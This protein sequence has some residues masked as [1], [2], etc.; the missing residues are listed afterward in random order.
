MLLGFLDEIFPS[1]VCT[2]VTSTLQ[3]VNWKGKLP[4]LNSARLHIG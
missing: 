4:L 2:Y 1:R 3:G